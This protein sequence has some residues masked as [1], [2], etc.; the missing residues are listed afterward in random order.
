[1]SGKGKWVATSTTWRRPVEGAAA[2]EGCGVD[3]GLAV[4]LGVG[5]ALGRAAPADSCAAAPGV[6]AAASGPWYTEDGGV[7]GLTAAST[8]GGEPATT[9]RAVTLVCPWGRASA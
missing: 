3:R 9:A 5:A 2:A 1:M 4:G 8:V 6:G 7:G